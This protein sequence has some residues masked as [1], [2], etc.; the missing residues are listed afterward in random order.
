MVREG[1]PQPRSSR[2]ESPVP[3]GVKVGPPGFEGVCVSGTE[4]AGGGRG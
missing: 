4:G 3:H 1:V 2:A